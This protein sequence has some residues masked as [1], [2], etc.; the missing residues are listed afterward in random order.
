MVKT[1]LHNEALVLLQKINSEIPDKKRV[2][3]LNSMMTG[4][5]RELNAQLIDNIVPKPVNKETE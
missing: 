5:I 2:D 1:D 3:T 4:V